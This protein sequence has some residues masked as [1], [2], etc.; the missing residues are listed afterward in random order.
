MNEKPVLPPCSAV[1]SYSPIQN[2]P[3]PSQVDTLPLPA[4]TIPND[5]H[6]DPYALADDLTHRFIGE[7]VCILI[8]GTRF[9][10]KG[11]RYGRGG[12][13][14]DR[15]LSSV[16]KEWVRIGVAVSECVSEKELK[17]E[18]WDEPVDWLVII[19][20]NGTESIQAS[21]TRT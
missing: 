16:P 5:T 13:W 4:F 11:T 3:D 8:P 17:R 20:D 10:R 15:F 9:D 18:S 7:A 14:Y 21:G 19:S 6:T 12:G 1:V 2:E